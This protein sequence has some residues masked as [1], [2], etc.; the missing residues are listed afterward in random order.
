MV[1]QCSFSLYCILSLVGRCCT[2]MHKQASVHM[3]ID[4]GELAEI[5]PIKLLIAS[6][7]LLIQILCSVLLLQ[8]HFFLFQVEVEF[9]NG[10]TFRLSAEFLRICSPA[11]DGKMRSVGG[12]KVDIQDICIHLLCI[13][14]CNGLI[15]F[16]KREEEFYVHSLNI[17]SFFFFFA[18]HVKGYCKIKMKYL[19]I[20]TSMIVVH[21]VA[22]LCVHIC[23]VKLTSSWRLEWWIQIF[24]LVDPINLSLNSTIAL[25]GRC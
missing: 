23:G 15:S 17:W 1:Q 9:T 20:S 25:L 6:H 2:T 3:F 16:T 12:E 4:S 11:A 21:L 24:F 5:H 14:K 18:P 10:S 7:H 22:L 19:A 8:I 13:Q